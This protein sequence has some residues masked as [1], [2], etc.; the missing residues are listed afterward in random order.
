MADFYGRHGSNAE[1]LLSVLFWTAIAGSVGATILGFT[2]SPKWVISILAALPAA[3]VIIVRQSRIQERAVWHNTFQIK[4]EALQLRL[5]H[6]KVP[7]PEIARDLRLV[8]DKMHQ[9]YP[10]IDF[11]FAAPKRKNRP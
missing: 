5:V 10:K 3:V 11:G 9:Q 2:P 1:L 7:V 8:S 6:E 4:L